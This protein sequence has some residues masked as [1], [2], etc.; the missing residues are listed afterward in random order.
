MAKATT[1]SQAVEQLDQLLAG[2]D[3]DGEFQYEEVEVIRFD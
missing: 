1:A 3:S 2:D